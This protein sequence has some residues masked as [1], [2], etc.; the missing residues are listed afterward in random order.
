MKGIAIFLILIII[1]GGVMFFS[2]PTKEDFDVFMEKKASRNIAKYTSGSSGRIGELTGDDKTT[3]ISYN[4][5]LFTRENYYV[6]SIYNSKSPT[7][8]DGE[9]YLGLFKFFIIM[10]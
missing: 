6:V 8:T 1:I 4:K 10:K 2:N 9:Q 5:T 3:V 7:Q